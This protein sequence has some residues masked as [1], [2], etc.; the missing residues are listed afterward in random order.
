MKYPLEHNQEGHVSL[1]GNSEG[2]VSAYPTDPAQHY[3][4]GLVTEWEP[5][6][7]LMA[8]GDE[9]RGPYPHEQRRVV[10]D[11]KSLRERIVRE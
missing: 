2:G 7:N 1:L 8:F 11:E 6:T 5:P 4:V 9:R 10:V 3:G